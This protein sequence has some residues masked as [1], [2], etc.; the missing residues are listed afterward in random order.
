MVYVQHGIWMDLPFGDEFGWKNQ[1]RERKFVGFM[2]IDDFSD[3]FSFSGDRFADTFLSG[4]SEGSDRPRG[5]AP[6]MRGS[7]NGVP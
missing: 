7:K 1:R 6:D 3:N 4:I 5:V 2:T